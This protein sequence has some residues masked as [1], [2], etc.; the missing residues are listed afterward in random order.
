ML[1]FPK[2]NEIK[3]HSF[4]INEFKGLDKRPNADFNS[5]SE[6]T[7]ISAKYSP[8]LTTRNG[9]RK[10]FTIQYPE[11]ITGIFAFDKVY[12]TASYKGSTRLYYGDDFAAL[13][14]VYTAEDDD[15]SSSMFCIFDGRVCIFNLKSVDSSQNAMSSAIS[16][17][18]VPSRFSA[19]IFNDITVYKNRVFG[20][21]RKQIRACADGVVHQWDY[22]QVPENAADRAFITSVE[23]RSE[24]V[25]CVTYRNRVL[26][27][28][29]DELFE[30]YGNDSD[31]FGIEKI[32]DFGCV[33]RLAVCEVG[34]VVYFLSKEGVVRYDGNSI[35]LIS[36]A[37]CDFSKYDTRAVL[38]GGGSTLYVKMAGRE[39]EH[40]Y[41]YDTQNKLWSKEGV[42]EGVSA[43]FYRGNTYF[44]DANSVYKMDVPYEDESSNN[45]GASFY[46]EAVTQD[47]YLDIPRKM[48]AS[49]LNVHIKRALEGNTEVAIS[50]DD[51]DF[52]TVGSFLTEG[53]KTICIPLPNIKS[54]KI[55]IKVC[56]WGEAQIGYISFSYTLG[57]EC[58]WQQTT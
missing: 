11:H 40:I 58:K 51:G 29:S 10:V 28:T 21:R 24:F 22:T 57:G 41:T 2:L 19:P 50:Y 33:N 49:K 12:L 17:I 6:T 39:D 13:S 46:W 38:G 52:Q 5:L 9:R 32:A 16:A 36:D 56:G 8:A 34:G 45:D 31:S 37:I 7:G 43:T 15:I 23:A 44:A 4:T 20:C 55:K 54:E 26:F 27:F 35:S 1:N 47:I 53:S 25:A 14:C 48:L 3:K 18:D 42:F 30:L